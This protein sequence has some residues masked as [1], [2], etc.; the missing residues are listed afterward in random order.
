MK[1]ITNAIIQTLLGLLWLAGSIEKILPGHQAFVKT[2]T[3]DINSFA[4]NNPYHFYQ[5]Y[6]YNS[7]LSHI[8]LYS[9]L[10]PWGELAVALMFFVGIYLVLV[11]KSNPYLS[12]LIIASLF[13]AIF[14]NINF[15]LA[16]GWTSPFIYIINLVMIVLE[17][18][19]IYYWLKV[20]N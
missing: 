17:A 2:L 9:Y 5:D 12:Y 7:V 19:Y 20:N 16:A 10:V 1:R 11:K 4:I 15:W 3:S 8:Q 13:G 18:I 6:L 14:M